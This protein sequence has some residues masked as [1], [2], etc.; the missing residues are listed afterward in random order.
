MTEHR[1]RLVEPR[2]RPY[3]FEPSPSS[4]RRAAAPLAVALEP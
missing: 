1:S 2:S 4:R 3:A